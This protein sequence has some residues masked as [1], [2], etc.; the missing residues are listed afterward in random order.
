MCSV[1]DGGLEIEL[2]QYNSV[3]REA[4][5]PTPVASGR[6]EEVICRDSEK[7]TSTRKGLSKADLTLSA[8]M[9]WAT[10]VDRMSVSRPAFCW[11]PSP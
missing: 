5:L 7:D 1:T 10:V 4:K 3:A 6:I 2:Q 9:L 8:G 11:L